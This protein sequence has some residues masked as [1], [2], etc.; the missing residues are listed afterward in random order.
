MTDILTNAA[1]YGTGYEASFSGMPVAGKTG[2]T[3]DDWD[4][5]FCGY[6]PYYVAA[7][8]TGYDSPSPI[9]WSGNPSAQTWHDIMSKIH[10]NLEYKSFDTPASTYQKAVPG[11]EVV[12]YTINYTAQ[13]GTILDSE[14]KESVHDREVK[15]TAK[16][17]D[18]YTLVG[19][20]TQTLKIDKDKENIITFIY[21]PNEPVTPPDTPD[22]PDP[23]N[24]DQP[25]TPPDNPDQ[26]VTPGT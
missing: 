17:F 2:T 20:A 19:E 26:P 3:S 14:T 5:W 6:T 10:E 11:V 13:D 22:P 4:R 23:D 9:S 8:W 12:K 21:A 7:V 1:S 25:V 15:A 16:E 18:G 24:P